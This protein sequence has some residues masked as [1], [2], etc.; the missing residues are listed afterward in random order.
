M[1]GHQLVMEWK[2]VW[3]EILIRFTIADLMRAFVPAA[4]WEAPFLQSVG[5]DFPGWLVTLEN[6]MVAPFVAAATFIGSMDNMPLATMLASSGV[7][8]AGLMV[9][10]Y[11]DPMVPPLVKV[12][13]RY[14]GWKVALYIAG[15]MFV[16][17]VCT[18]LILDAGFG[19]FRLTPE[20][21]AS[22]ATEEDFAIDY[23]FFFNIACVSVA[24]T[25]LWLNGR[26]KSSSG[27]GDG[28]DHDHGGGG[29]GVQ[30]VAAGVA[31]ALLAIGIVLFFVV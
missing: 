23:T 21:A 29:I 4:F 1:V 28:G 27:D 14:Y 10:I 30:D 16:S 18:A 22:T 3:Q 24:A 31:I 15:I 25:L 13:A 11:S 26:H 8:F 6:V 5:E 9:F 19:L 7:G 17:I 20:G 2:M 12:N